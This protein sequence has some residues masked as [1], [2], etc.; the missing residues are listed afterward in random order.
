MTLCRM[1]MTLRT[2]S[3]YKTTLFT[4]VDE[5]WK[6]N[7]SATVHNRHLKE[8]HK[9]LDVLYPCLLSLY[10]NGISKAFTEDCIYEFKDVKYDKK[11]GQLEY[12]KPVKLDY[13][14]LTKYDHVQSP[15]EK[16]C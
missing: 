6:G 16:T 3:D 13:S 1:L 2:K 14:L 8:A 10:G 11:R 7:F 9:V 12:L 15:A 5:D 4:Q